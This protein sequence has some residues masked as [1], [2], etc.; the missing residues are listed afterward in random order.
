MFLAATTGTQ[1]YARI[2]GVTLFN[3]ALLWGLRGGIANSPDNSHPEWHVS[4]LELVRGLRPRVKALADAEN[5][6]QTIDPAGILNN[7]LF[8]EYEQTPKVDLRVD[9]LP[10]A[11]T[12]GSQGLL[13]D[14]QARI[15]VQNVSD[16]PMEERLDAGIYK[17]KIDTPDGFLNFSDFL[18][19]SPPDEYREIDV[20]S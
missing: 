16:W 11:A 20:T 19:L 14:G 4:T 13:E 8:H 6:E 10:T 7:A 9:L 15:V 2:G 17:I 12:A 1:A 3:E 18:S 5:A